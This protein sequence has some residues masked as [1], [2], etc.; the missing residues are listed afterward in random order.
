MLAAKREPKKMLHYCDNTK[1]S[2]SL[3][4]INTVLCNIPN[5]TPITFRS[6]TEIIS[7]SRF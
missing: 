7:L 2:V 6:E 5:I 3:G 4:E 1:D